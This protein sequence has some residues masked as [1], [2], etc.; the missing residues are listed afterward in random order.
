VFAYQVGLVRP[1]HG[2]GVGP[3]A[4][5]SA[6]AAAQILIAWGLSASG[7]TLVKTDRVA[8]STNAAPSP[9]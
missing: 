5:A 4:G 7:N 3:I 8:G 1:E 2:E 6:L 9:N